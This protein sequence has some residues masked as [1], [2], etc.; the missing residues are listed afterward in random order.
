MVRVEK[1]GIKPGKIDNELLFPHHHFSRPFEKIDKE[2]NGVI[3]RLDDFFNLVRRNDS[4]AKMIGKM[5]LFH[6]LEFPFDSEVHL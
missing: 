4:F 2:Q 1:L 3:V 6:L 5:L